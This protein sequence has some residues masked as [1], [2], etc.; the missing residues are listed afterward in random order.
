MSDSSKPRY[1]VEVA[2]EPVGPIG[3]NELVE[4]I[5]AGVISPTDMVWVEG[6]DKAFEAA[7]FLP[8]SYFEAAEND[9]PA[10]SAN[11]A[12]ET[13]SSVGTATAG[14]GTVTAIIGAGCLWVAIPILCEIAVGA[15]VLGYLFWH[16]N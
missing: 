2:G 13:L 6:T 4:R 10:N 5:V 8:P 12:M 16:W 14:V 9:R 15:L 3:R 7:Q 1:F 11:G